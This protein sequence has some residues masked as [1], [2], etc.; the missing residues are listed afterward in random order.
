MRGF[1]AWSKKMYAAEESKHKV[2]QDLNE[3]NNAIT[4]LREVLNEME[5]NKAR[6]GVAVKEMKAKLAKKET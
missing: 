2:E 3:G 6:R 1:S 5:G 4:M